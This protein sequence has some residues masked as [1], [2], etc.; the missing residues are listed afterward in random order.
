MRRLVFFP[1]NSFSGAIPDRLLD[2]LKRLLFLA[3]GSGRQRHR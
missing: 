3:G 1:A 2:T